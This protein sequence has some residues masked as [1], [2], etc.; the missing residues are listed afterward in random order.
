MRIDDPWQAEAW[1]AQ[2]FGGSETRWAADAVGKYEVTARRLLDRITADTAVTRIL[3][4]GT[5]QLTL[6]I[7]SDMSQRQLERDY[8]SAPD[9]PELPSLVLVAENADEYQQDHEYSRA[10]LGLPPIA[11]R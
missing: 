1:R 2:H 8:Y 11:P 3:V 4:C 9:D 6:A 5:S 7:C 10:Q